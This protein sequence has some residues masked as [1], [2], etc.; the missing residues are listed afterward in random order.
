MEFG[1]KAEKEYWR[2]LKLLKFDSRRLAA[3]IE[4]GS[5]RI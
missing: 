3:E 2:L 1:L 5:K 4:L